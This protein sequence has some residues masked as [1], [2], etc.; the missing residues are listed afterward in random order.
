[1]T[2]RAMQARRPYETP[3]LQSF[4]DVRDL[5]QAVLPVGMNGDGG[6]FLSKKV[7]VSDAVLKRSIT[8]IAGGWYRR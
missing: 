1:M 2:T 4:G 6:R 5:T 7:S 3:K 8:A